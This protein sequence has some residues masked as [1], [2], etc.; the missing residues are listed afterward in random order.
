MRIAGMGTFEKEL[1]RFYTR[2]IDVYG[3]L[4]LIMSR[5]PISVYRDGQVGI[6]LA[7][8]AQP[9]FIVHLAAV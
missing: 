6:S 7:S 3:Y 2:M 9:M 8:G 1:R 5:R 4:K